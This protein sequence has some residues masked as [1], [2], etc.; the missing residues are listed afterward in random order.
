MGKIMVVGKAEREYEANECSINLEIEV[1]RKTSSEASKASS[2]QCELLLS[3]LQEELG[4]NPNSIEIHYDRIDKRS[5]Y[6]SNEINY[7]SKRSLW[8]H[9]P[10]DMKLVNAIRRI[11]E[12][13]FEDV[14]FTSMYS[15]SNEAALNKELF[16]EAIADS[17]AKADF[18][19]ESMG[20]TITGIDSANLSGDEDVYD[21][22]EE[23]VEIVRY[24]MSAAG[25]SSLSDQLKPNQ[26]ELS[27]EVKI[28]W[29]VS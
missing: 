28:V 25:S 4:I 20:L 15:V 27:A 24:K 6:N 9:I 19:A 29:L 23:P 2:E 5:S 11:I 7:E 21:L 14:S 12:T 22:T 18:L 10:A 3:K 8:L 26:V 1:S 13:G 16:K 17:R